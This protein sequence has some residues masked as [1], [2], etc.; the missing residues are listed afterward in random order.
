MTRSASSTSIATSS[1]SQAGKMEKAPAT[2]INNLQ[3][4]RAFAA[5]AVAW[6]HTGYIPLHRH[7]V[8]A[9]GVDIFFALSGYIMARICEKNADFFLRRRLIRIVPP[10]WAFT[11]LLFAL[12]AIEPHWMTSTRASAPDLLRSLFFVPFYK[13]SGLIRPLLFVGWSLN[14][15]MLFYLSIAIGLYVIRKS[16]ILF[17]SL[18]IIALHLGA[19]LIP[20]YVALLDF[21]RE[22]F[23]LE[24]PAGVLVYAVAKRVT[25]EQAK[26]IRP[27][28]L[29]LLLLSL[30]GF[31]YLGLVRPAIGHLSE[32]S[33]YVGL[34]ALS[35]LSASLLSQG[36]WDTRLASVIL[37]GDASYI[38]YLIHPYCEY[39]LYRVFVRHTPSLAGDH[40][41]G[42]L[43]GVAF[44]LVTGVILHV[45][46][47][48]PTLR[49]LNK[50]FGGHRKSAEF[51]VLMETKG[52]VKL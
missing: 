10:Y 24:F 46:A 8:G 13:E 35:V 47:E 42:S 4:L 36:G 39:F 22:N 6:F 21:L 7:A 5:L 2:K 27:L 15:E 28:S 52:Q 19:L 50:R 18:L 40:L 43:L 16:A 34:S 1:G 14:Y 32:A 11:I 9:F 37:I 25:Q 38:L 3:A 33:L 41:P 12:A 29:L 30:C 23:I 26:R 48:R 31:G 49:Y 44:A 20:G 45:Y 17:A 51:G